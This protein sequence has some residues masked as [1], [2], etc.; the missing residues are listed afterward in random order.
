MY[1]QM[2]GVQFQQAGIDDAG[3]LLSIKRAAIGGIDSS[4]YDRGQLEA[5]QPDVD[6]A[7]D[8]ER[9]IGSDTFDVVLARVDGTDVAYGV[10]NATAGRIDALYVRPGYSGEGIATSLVGQLESRARMRGVEEIEIISSLNARPFYETLGYR[11]CGAKHRSI[12]GADLEF[13]VM[14]KQIGSDPDRRT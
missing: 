1:E 6:A 14:R 2:V 10:L 11:T 9:A 8:F 3:T 4:V 13:A 7:S 5:W 12:D